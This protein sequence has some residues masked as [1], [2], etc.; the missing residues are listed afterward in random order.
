MQPEQ[1]VCEVRY[2][3]HG[4][5]IPILRE[6]IFK[7]YPGFLLAVAVKIDAK[8]QQALKSP[9]FII[10]QLRVT[11][12]FQLEQCG[13]GFPCKD[14][15]KA[16]EISEIILAK[17][18]R[19]PIVVLASGANGFWLGTANNPDASYDKLV[20]FCFHKPQKHDGQLSSYSLRHFKCRLGK[21]DEMIKEEMLLTTDPEVAQKLL[22]AREAELKREEVKKKEGDPSAVIAKQVGLESAMLKESQLLV[23]AKGFPET[24]KFFQSQDKPTP[25]EVYAAY[26][27]DIF[28]ATGEMQK[29]LVFNQE[30]FEKTARA[31]NNSRRREKMGINPLEYALVAGWFFHGYGMMK[32]DM[33]AAELKKRGLEKISPEAMRKLCKRLKLPSLRKAGIH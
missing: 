11:E 14:E 13:S 17:N 26:Q 16:T 24:V 10:F 30:Q 32:P 5:R 8:E 19:V 29:P 25:E 20:L 3:R 4:F 27:R 12:K 21:P 22:E 1:I 33:R 31:F 7:C 23:L 18:R 15:A 9:E 2:Q 28:K 6:Q